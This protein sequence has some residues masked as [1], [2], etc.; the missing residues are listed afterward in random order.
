[1]AD[2]TVLRPQ[3]AT[4]T[5]YILV[6]TTHH[7]SESEKAQLRNA[8]AEIIEY[9]EHDTYLCHYPPQSLEPVRALPFVS[10]ANPYFRGFKLDPALAANR[11]PVRDEHLVVMSSLQAADL[12]SQPQE[13]EIVFHR[14]VNPVNQ[15]ARVASLAWVPL[16]EHAVGPHKI[17]AVVS[18]EAI[19]ALTTLD[20]VRHIEKAL[21]E[22]LC[23]DQARQ[24]LQIPT[25]N[26]HPPL[27]GA[28]QVVVI[29]D[30]G[31]DNGRT[32]GSVH[33]AFT[34]RVLRLYA[35]GRPPTNEGTGNADD[36]QGHGTHVAGSALGDG[37]SAAFGIQIQGAAPGA[38]LVLQSCFNDT[39]DLDGLPDDLT[40]LFATPY[41]ADGARI[42]S[43]SWASPNSAGVYR[44]RA[45][46]VDDFVFQHRDCLILF[47]SGNDG[48]DANPA[49]GVI[50]EG[51]VSLPG[52]AKNCVTV[53]AS[54]S[55]RLNPFQPD[56]APVTL[57]WDSPRFPLRPINGD[58]RAN[59]PDGMAA[60]SGRG[61][62]QQRRIK[63]DIIAPG[64]FILSTRS[65]HMS[66]PP[67]M[68]SMDADYMFDSGT[69]MATPLVAGCAALV[70]E[71]LAKERQIATPS[72]ALLKALLINGARDIPGQ[73]IPSEAPEI[74][75]YSEGFGR[76]DVAATVNYLEK[77]AR[78]LAFWDEATA[79][80]G[81]QTEMRTISL[82]DGVSQV[83]VTLVWTD[84][85]G[86]GLQND[87][88]LIVRDT[89]GQECHGNRKIGDPSFDTDNNVEQIV[90]D[91]PSQGD[92]QI[93]IRATRI[94]SVAQSYVLV[95]R[96]I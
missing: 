46:E 88:D 34:G 1:M 19:Q 7:P 87:L 51:S 49:D 57:S 22:E 73:Y 10:W 43:N 45:F 75:N 8:G 35:L 6:Q 44:Q 23:N 5:D 64:T 78:T 18:P 47:A 36:P 9:V 91:R 16:T 95:V 79:L 59:N 40:Q 50:D 66:A 93:T 29:A 72:A 26:P 32:D 94:T 42:H 41:N 55:F 83:K 37:A 82:P 56:P 63:P 70:R 68:P 90:W 2:E 3:N 24:I 33:P 76:V 48:V 13:V 74:P 14:N 53:G 27:T 15:L 30:T 96:V 71:W 17:R 61:P 77:Y 84:P 65:R 54:E 31:L 38:Q 39:G 21:P 62:T 28:G 25:G 80:N 52:T 69:S 12:G 86:A 20:T 11:P 58:L 4:E 67:A 60:F 89:N 85:P 92:L 81:E